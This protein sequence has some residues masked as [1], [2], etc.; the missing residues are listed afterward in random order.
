MPGVVHG[1]SRGRCVRDGAFQPAV[2]LDAVVVLNHTG[3]EH[4]IEAR[5]A[6]RDALRRRIGL[7]HSFDIKSEP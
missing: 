5:Q 7:S 6:I 3:S 4:A 2:L 1:W